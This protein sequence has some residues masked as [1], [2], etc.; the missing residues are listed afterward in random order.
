MK[1]EIGLTC[2]NFLL[3]NYVKALSVFPVCSHV[4]NISLAL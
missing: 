1:F 3:L 4:K 2:F